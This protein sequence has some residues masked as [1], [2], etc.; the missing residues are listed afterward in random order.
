MKKLLATTALGLLVAMPV[1]AQTASTDTSVQADATTKMATSSD[2]FYEGVSGAVMASDFIGKR[3]YAAE[4]GADD[5]TEY[6]EADANWD[7]IGEISDVIIS[8][9]GD[10]EAVLVDV[11]GFLGIGEKTVAVNLSSLDMVSDG[12]DADDYFIVMTGNRQALEDA[13]AFNP[14]W[15]EMKAGMGEAVDTAQT[16][17]AAAGAAVGAAADNAGDKIASA[18]DKAADWTKEQA[19][20][21]EAAMDNAGDDVAATADDMTTDMMS[22]DWSDM[23]A[24]ELTGETIYGANDEKVGTVDEVV[25]DDQMKVT[26]VIV[27][28][29]GFLGLGAKQ[30][31]LTPDQLELM[32]SDT[33][34]T[35]HVSATEDE[36]K[37]MP[38]YKS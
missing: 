33:G 38:E 17:A 15:D 14:D 12:D 16:K 21:A 34:I 13:P 27:D 5:T 35:V 37:A 7:D 3:V 23:T 11:G 26:D 36:L 32:Q 10:V 30:V 6:T 9:D 29:G 1:T 18:T 19:A 20:D 4:T 31:A 22:A 2:T 24:E 25:V 28:V 8:T